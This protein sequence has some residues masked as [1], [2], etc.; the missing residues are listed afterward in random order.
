MLGRC[1][2]EGVEVLTLVLVDSL[3]LHIKQRVG[4]DRDAAV[5][6][7]ILRQHELRAGAPDKGRRR[8]PLLRAATL[9]APTESQ[10]QDG[11]AITVGGQPPC[12]A[13]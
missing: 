9:S 1:V 6:L 10:G 5:A 3:H 4:V 11:R 13:A 7:D 12:C 8:S 2:P